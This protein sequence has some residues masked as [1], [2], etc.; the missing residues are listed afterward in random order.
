MARAN[1]HWRPGHWRPGALYFPDLAFA[2]H[3]AASVTRSDYKALSAPFSPAPP[4]SS[5]SQRVHSSHLCP[6][7]TTSLPPSNKIYDGPTSFKTSTFKPSFSSRAFCHGSPSVEPQRAKQEK[8]KLL[9]LKQRS[10]GPSSTR[11]VSVT[12][13]GKPRDQRS[14]AK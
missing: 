11:E 9:G 12:P 8:C 3:P 14:L 13:P 4:T 2:T 1:R 10:W 7:A 6:F 5:W